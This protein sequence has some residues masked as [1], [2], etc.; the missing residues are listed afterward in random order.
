M[1]FSFSSAL[2]C[3]LPYGGSSGV[4]GLCQPTHTGDEVPAYP[5][6]SPLCCLCF[7]TPVLHHICSGVLFPSDRKKLE[8]TCGRSEQRVSLLWSFYL[9]W[10]RNIQGMPEDMQKKW[11]GGCIDCGPLC[12][13]S[14]TPFLSKGPDG[15]VQKASAD[16]RN[17]SKKIY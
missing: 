12:L 3:R 10:W 8:L 2:P 17:I 13:A 6:S 9:S 5:C 4:A 14:L 16:S 15:G 11:H 7:V 1:I